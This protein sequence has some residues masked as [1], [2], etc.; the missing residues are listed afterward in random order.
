MATITIY[1]E[2]LG[3][4]YTINVTLQYSVISSLDDGKVS[5]YLSASTT[6]RDPLGQ[7]IGPIVVT[8]TDPLWGT[9]S[10]VVTDVVSDVIEQIITAITG[11]LLSS[12]SSSSSSSHS[13]ASSSS[14][15]SSLNSSSSS[16]SSTSSVNS[17]SS[18]TSSNP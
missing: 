14:S 2:T 6:A 17:S 15:A 10:G 8:D 3:T 5:Y 13:S 9:Y 18:S 7:V 12:S 4:T 11:G 16:T 1:D